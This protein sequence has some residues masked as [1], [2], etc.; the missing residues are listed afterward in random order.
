MF[1]FQ[2]LKD[3]LTFLGFENIGDLQSPLPDGTT[4]VPTIIMVALFA[5]GGF[6]WIAN[7][8]VV[9]SIIRMSCSS[10]KKVKVS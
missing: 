5:R 10:Y 6:L 9:I 3:Y 4:S 2:T 7:L 8:S 1:I